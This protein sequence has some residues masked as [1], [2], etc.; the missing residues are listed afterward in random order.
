MMRIASAGSAARLIVSK[1]FRPTVCMT[2]L[3]ESAKARGIKPFAPTSENLSDGR[4][5]S[6]NPPPRIAGH[7][8][9]FLFDSDE[10][11]V[12][13]ETVGAGEAAGLD[14]PAI[15][16]DGEVRDGGVLG[17]AGAVRHDRGI[18]GAVR[19]LDRF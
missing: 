15:G 10:L 4:S 13:G 7:R 12:L 16:R 1:V 3:T 14:L 18:A 8:A 19:H 11:V 2:S 9:Q 5:R 6:E 17:L